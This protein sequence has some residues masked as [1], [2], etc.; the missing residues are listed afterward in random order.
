MKEY[1]VEGMGIITEEELYEEYK[2]HEEDIGMT[3]EEWKFDIL[4]DERSAIK[5]I[6]EE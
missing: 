6:G 3:Y 2:K 5:E 1:E 4:H